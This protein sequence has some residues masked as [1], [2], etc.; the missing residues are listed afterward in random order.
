MSNALDKF[1][2]ILM[3]K[4]RDKSITDWEKIFGGEMRGRTAERVQNQLDSFDSVQMEALMKI[5]PH[6]VGTT[7]H[8]LLWTLSQDPSVKLSIPN[9]HG[10]HQNMVNLSDGT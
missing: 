8:H 6:I 1:G 4:V 10:E 3:K 5:L 9:E 2:G 7:L